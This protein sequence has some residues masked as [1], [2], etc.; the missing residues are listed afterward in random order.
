MKLDDLN[1]E[2]T[3]LSKSWVLFLPNSKLEL[4]TDNNKPNKMY[5]DFKTISQIFTWNYQ[6][7]CQIY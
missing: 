2:V 4:N 7:I 3:W 5:A 1:E 6:I